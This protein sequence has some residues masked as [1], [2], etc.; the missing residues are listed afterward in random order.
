M[1]EYFAIEHNS[2]R[3]KTQHNF[4]VLKQH[5]MNTARQSF[6]VIA[7]TDRGPFTEIKTAKIRSLIFSIPD[8]YMYIMS[9]GEVG[10][11]VGKNSLTRERKGVVN[12]CC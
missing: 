2:P 10:K 9:S 12:R 3:E 11:Y 6:H 5:F 8:Y 1:C 7:S 4:R